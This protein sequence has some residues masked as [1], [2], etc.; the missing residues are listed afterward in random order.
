MKKSAGIVGT[1]VA[2]LATAIRLACKGYEVEVFES[3]DYPGGKLSELQ[4]GKYR[5]DA[6]PSLFTLPSLV[7]DLFILAGK[8]PENHF[9]YKRLD[10]A[11]HYFFDDGTTLKAYAD[12]D[13]L[14]AELEEKLGEPAHN[15][16]VSM[17]HSAFLYDKLEG[18]F[19]HRSLH[20]P[21]TFL[22][23]QAFEAYAVLRK[24]DLFDTMDE[25]NK[26]RF[27]QAKT[28]QLFNRYATY[29]GSSPYLTPAT[30]NII[31]H[32]EFG[33]GAFIPEKGMHQITESLFELAK[34]VGV[35]FHFNSRVEKIVISGK[36]VTGLV[37][38]GKTLPFDYV[39]SNM[40]MVA[41]YK[42]LLA[43]VKAP[44]R[45]LNQPKSSS[46]LIFYWGIKKQFDELGLHNIFFSSDYKEEF[47]HIFSK[48]TIYSDPTVYVNIT[49]KEVPG[50]AP[51]GCENWFTMI[52]VPHNS[53][54]DWATLKA[55]ARAHILAKLSRVLKTDI[56][57]L[58]EEEG[59]LDPIS[60]ESKTSSWQGALYG[61]SSNNKYAA[62]LRHSNKSGRVKNL[63]FC[64]GSVH[65]GGGIPL[66]LSSAK[67]VADYFPQL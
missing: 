46:A 10:I 18:L 60:I 3:N 48:Q 65:P 20:E 17:E 42:T 40:D 58:I 51:K 21:R 27:K 30:M 6:G 19:I 16:R 11:T 12:H 43:D 4:L 31:P 37:S 36:K 33:I 45:L 66:C 13:K 35:T 24:L 52:N 49:S 62:F 14:A 55:E 39:V 47:D 22:N 54:Q 61:N 53:G 23:K 15:I 28:V 67:I 29:N 59:V 64:G 25:A 32:L 38:K 57:P 9:R 41:T 50:E 34:S 63:Y 2:G 26:R 44:K 1:G 8:T 5:F 7:D 56:V